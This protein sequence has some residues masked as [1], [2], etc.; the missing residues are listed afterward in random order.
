MD[1][2]QVDNVSVHPWIMMGAI[3]FGATANL[4]EK[5]SVSGRVGPLLSGYDMQYIR[6]SDVGASGTSTSIATESF[7]TFTRRVSKWGYGGFASLA[8]GYQITE[9]FAITGELMYSGFTSGSVNQTYTNVTNLAP[10][11]PA[12]TKSQTGSLTP[13]YI[14]DAMGMIG[15]Q[16]RF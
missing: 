3:Y 2:A 9:H 5:L 7:S 16:F 13:S 11:T 12:D 14:S 1:I 4:N 10:T 6:S 8:A 15:A